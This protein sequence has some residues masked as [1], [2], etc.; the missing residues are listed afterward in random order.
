[1][2]RFVILEGL[3]KGGTGARKNLDSFR[4]RAK[5]PGPSSSVRVLC[6]ICL[7]TATVPIY[8]RTCLP[9]SPRAFCRKGHTKKGTSSA[10]KRVAERR[11]PPCP[12]HLTIAILI[13][14]RYFR[15]N[16]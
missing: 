10:S 6:V 2:S 1:M 9:I 8:V 7:S 12:H 13:P 3:E 5:L 15:F 11:I 14:F 16:P 4:I